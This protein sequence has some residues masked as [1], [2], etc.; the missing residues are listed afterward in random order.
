[1]DNYTLLYW[2]VNLLALASVCRI[3]LRT[4]VC[5]ANCPQEAISLVHGSPKGEP[6]A[7]TLI[8]RLPSDPSLREGLFDLANEQAR[9]EGFVAERDTGQEELLL[10]WD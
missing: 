2:H 9:K 5:V 3:P 4:G 8:V 7:H 1:M 10:W 6:Y